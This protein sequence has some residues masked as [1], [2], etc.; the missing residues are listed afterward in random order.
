MNKKIVSLL[1]AIIFIAA[2]ADKSDS[3][4]LSIFRAEAESLCRAHSI[5]HW[6][7]IGKF[8]ALDDMNPTEKAN[9]LAQEISS[10]VSL[11]NFQ[12]ILTKAENVRAKDFYSYLQVEIPKLTKQ[13]F[14]CPHIESFYRAK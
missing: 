5:E 12:D 2:C 10:S 13:P 8:D 4:T 7:E 1:A 9:V 3:N 6:K 14:D 11:P